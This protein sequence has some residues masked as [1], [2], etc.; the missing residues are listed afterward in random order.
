MNWEMLAAF[1]QLTAALVGIPSII[2]LAL[3]IRAQT[4]ERRE[5]AA[6]TLTVQWGD[7]TKALH[8]TAEFS[9]LFL[10]GLQSFDEMD[11]VSKLRFSAF[12]NRFFNY[13]KGMYFFLSRGH[14]DRIVMEGS[15]SDDE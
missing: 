7:L 3:Q 8:E 11:A 6:N 14:P 9:A 1:G 5:A 15:G 4:R 12:F 2:Y 10:R 13:F